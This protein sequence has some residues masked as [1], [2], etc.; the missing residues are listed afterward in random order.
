MKKIY[1]AIFLFVALPAFAQQKLDV[2]ATTAGGQKVI[3]H[4]GGRWDFAGGPQP[5][6]TATES[7]PAQPATATQSASQG[8]PPGWQGGLFGIG[9]CIPPGDKDYNRGTMNPS[10]R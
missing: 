2:E 3:L 4:P 9:H 7:K 6:A 5:A 1:P 8:C 10:K